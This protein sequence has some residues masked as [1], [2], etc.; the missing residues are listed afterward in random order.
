DVD[1]WHRRYGHPGISLI[2]A[3][4]K[5]QIVDGMD[6]DTDSPFTICGPCIKGKHERIPFPSSKTRAKA[7]LELVH[8]DL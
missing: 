8:A 4:I 2:L 6:A 1:L 5:N 7:P 3:M